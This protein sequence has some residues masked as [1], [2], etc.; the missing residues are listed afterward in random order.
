VTLGPV[1]SGSRLTDDEVVRPEEF[2]VRTGPDKIHGSW[3]KVDKDTP[4]HMP[5][6]TKDTVSLDAFLLNL[7]NWVKVW[8]R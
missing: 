3:F 8:Q 1:V 6:I 2:P 5:V 4:G 7:G